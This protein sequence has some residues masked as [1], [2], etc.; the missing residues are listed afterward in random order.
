MEEKRIP[1]W[2]QASQWF[3]QAAITIKNWYVTRFGKYPAW[4]VAL[5]SIGIL[6]SLMIIFFLTISALTFLGAFGKLPDYSTLKSI[7]NSTASEVYSEDDILI[8]K[9]YVEN[10]INAEFEEIS[11]SLIHA[12]IATEDARFFEHS[13][14]DVRAWFRV[15]F[16]TVLMDDKSSGGGSTLSQQLAKNLFPRELH[17]LF[18]ILISKLKESF[19]ARRLEA[20]YSKEDLLRLYLNTVPFG[21]DI[22]GIKV[23]AQRFFRKSPDE[24]EVQ[25]AAVLIGM[26]KGN[27][28]YHPVRHPDR[29]LKRRNTVLNQMLKYDYLTLQ[30]CDSLK[31]LPLNLEA[32]ESGE[33]NTALYF[34]EHLRLKIETLLKDYKKPDGTPYDL[35]RDGLRIYT[36]INS[37][38]Q[39]YAEEAVREHM[40]V[41]QSQFYNEWKKGVPWGKSNVLKQAIEKSDRYK[42]FKQKGLSEAEIEAAMNEKVKM[43]VY[44]WKT[45]GSVEKEISPID[46]IKF[47]LTVLN[48]GFLAMDSHTGQV[49]AWVGG[50]NYSFLQYDHVKATRQVGSTFKPVVYSEALIKGMLPCEYSPN[51]PINFPEFE[52]WQP[53]NSDGKYG[54]VYSMEGALSHSVN[55]VSV[56]VLLRAGIEAVV[57]RA[58]KL[59]IT[60]NI[61]VVPSIALGTMDASLYE[62]V[63]VYGTFAN[64]GKRPEMYYLDRIE[65]SDGKV[66]VDFEKP[67]PK[68]F[69]QVIPDTIAYTMTHMLTT[70]VDSGT[71]KRL[72]YHYGLYNPIAGKT[73]TTQNNSDGWF[74]GYTPK[75]V[76]GA[77]VG[78]ESPAIHF[79]SLSAGQGANT[80]LPIWGKFMQKLY[81]D[82]AFKSMK[83]GAFIDLAP[84]KKALLQCPPYLDEMPVIADFWNENTDDLM[85]LQ[86]ELDFVDLEKLYE[87]LQKKPKRRFESIWDYAE[88][89]SKTI[90]KEERRDERR[91]NRKAFWKDLIF[92]GKSKENDN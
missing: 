29:A 38:M 53:Q 49:K 48:S 9:Y 62:M 3:G 35:S 18:G 31:Q 42:T 75:L 60:A 61:P 7:K 72:R 5:G 56:E 68:K 73:G 2:Q 52:N 10:R 80:A 34:T 14:V 17:P 8:R 40:A 76:A 12:L 41:L 69:V 92:G 25:E 50:I 26:L 91:E 64:G 32:Y 84:E 47:Y 71:A 16:K 74:I 37:K 82:P 57:D 86:R 59:G 85:I 55:I 6:F 67:D 83:Q 22:F 21:D 15:A 39:Q 19:I 66:I 51:D 30:V 90:E 23:A 70:V 33:H 27:S 20:I 89:L 43:V 36:T 88:R 79:K 44:D 58:K 78:A 54:G 87:L 11:P 77:W 1:F 45:G 4:L 13:G 81:K 24:L 28:L 65:T 46:S 63:G